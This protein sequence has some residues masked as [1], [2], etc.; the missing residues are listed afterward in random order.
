MSDQSNI[1]SSSITPKIKIFSDFDGTITPVDVGN[2][3]FEYF[4][5][6]DIRSDI[7]MYEQ[8]K[9]VAKELFRRESLRIR[10][11]TPEKIDVFCQHYQVDSSFIPFYL[12][13]RK[14]EIYLA[15]ISDGMDVYVHRILNRYQI[16]LPVFCNT[17]RI[18]PDLTVTPEFPYDDEESIDCANCKRNHL[19]TR[20]SADDIIVMI[21]DGYS[22]RCPARYADIVFASG[23]LETYCQQENISFY[24]FNNF[25]D[26]Q[27]R[28]ESL[29][30][31]KRI[32]RPM[33]AR[34]R[35]RAI[36]MRG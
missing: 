20:S 26:I 7:E 3:F 16:E 2:A 34:L 31:K 35:R 32:R 18:N 28:L 9:I 27:K 12:W 29:L 5:G 17:L 10:N 25:T 13:C 30:S 22:D 8:G 19:L 21:G 23:S 14:K 11:I 1:S 36:W 24:S 15:I 33:Q 4:G 6:K